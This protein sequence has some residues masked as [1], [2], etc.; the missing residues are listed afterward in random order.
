M[1]MG[2]KR[3]KRVFTR[4]YLC[5]QA[6]FRQIPRIPAIAPCS[7]LQ[8]VL[9][10]FQDIAVAKIGHK[11]THTHIRVDHVRVDHVCKM[12]RNFLLM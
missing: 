8:E 2:Q 10:K 11:L 7:L 1:A 4:L 5:H 9:K 12:D 3:Y 6:L